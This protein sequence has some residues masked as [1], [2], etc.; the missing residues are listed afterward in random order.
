M[1]VALRP[2]LPTRPLVERELEGFSF[3][4][5][6]VLAQERLEGSLLRVPPLVPFAG[7]VRGCGSSWTVVALRRPVQLR[8]SYASTLVS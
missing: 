8:C 2:P 5:T 3:Y 6:S 1:A 4:R 7:S